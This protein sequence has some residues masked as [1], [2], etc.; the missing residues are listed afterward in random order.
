MGPHRPPTELFSSRPR[1]P[2]NLKDILPSTSGVPFRN[3]KRIAPAARTTSSAV[4]AATYQ[5]VKGYGRGIFPRNPGRTL[6]PSKAA[7]DTVADPTNMTIEPV[8]GQDRLPTSLPTPRALPISGRHWAG[9]LLAP[10]LGALGRGSRAGQPTSLHGFAVS[11]RSHT[12]KEVP[13]S[14]AGRPCAGDA[15]K[16]SAYHRLNISTHIRAFVPVGNGHNGRSLPQF[17]GRSRSRT[18]SLISWAHVPHPDRHRALCSALLQLSRPAPLPG[19][20]R[21]YSVPG[22][23]EG[24]TRRQHGAGTRLSHRDRP[25]GLAAGEDPWRQQQDSDG[26]FLPWTM[27]GRNVLPPLRVRRHG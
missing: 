17:A 9:R 2:P 27:G 7:Q 22:R 1:P 3:V 20:E 4:G 5:P 15:G 26:V 23:I 21:R 24:G 16:S 14:G 13:A 25:A 8:R 18:P 12:F 10:V 11:M 19:P 6:F